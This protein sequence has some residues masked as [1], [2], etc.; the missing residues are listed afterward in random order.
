MS[1]D[2]PNY[3]TWK[4]PHGSETDGWQPDIILPT[5]FLCA[6][7]L[8]LAAIL[9]IHV[10]RQSYM[11]ATV[12]AATAGSIITGMGAYRRDV[13][14]LVAGSSFL[15]GLLA[16]CL[17]S[18]PVALGS[19][20]SA[21]WPL[22]LGLL[23]LV[24]IA[25]V[26]LLSPPLWVRRAINAIAIPGLLALAIVGGP[27]LAFQWFGWGTP[28]TQKFPPLWLATA[29]DGTLYATNI[30]GNYL[31]V[32]SPLGVPL[33][34]IWPG[35][36]PGV[37]TPGPG[38]VTMADPDPSSRAI[39]NSLRLM[40]PI[41]TTLT[42]E[43][44]LSFPLCG[45]A[46]DTLDR[47]Y[48]ADNLNRELLQFDKNGIITARWPL[49]ITFIGT[50][51]CLAADDRHVYVASRSLTLHIYDFDGN[52]VRDIPFDFDI[53]SIADDGKGGLYVLGSGK[54]EKVD[55][56]TGQTEKLVVLPPEGQQFASYQ[57]LIVKPD[58]E[59]VVADRSNARLLRLAPGGR[60]VGSIGERGTLPGQFLTPGGLALDPRGTLYVADWALGAV[61]RF[62]SSGEF[63]AAWTAPGEKLVRPLN[64]E[65]G[66]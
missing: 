22:R 54:L 9:P 39:S 2:A 66:E 6:A 33:G 61:Q 25:W 55:V 31:W 3:I 34:T 30:A 51:G 1:S 5:L 38:I 46:V 53:E 48:V 45:V 49:P 43:Q 41:T 64:E 36:A 47:L 65:E 16:L 21:A 32:F 15:A 17:A 62:S 14:L 18:Q 60:I 11:V 7:T 35:A 23:G 27:S 10:G 52:R 56:E 29:S 4:D 37:G 50:A 19:P 8:L 63:E 42:A 59:I 24:V 20:L 12:L 13:P 40:E 44:T 58:G 28:P 26:V 57:T